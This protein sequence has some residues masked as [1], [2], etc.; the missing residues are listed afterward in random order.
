MH[1]VARHQR[2]RRQFDPLTVALDP[3]SE[4]QPLFEELERG[5]STALLE[6]A[7]GDVENQKDADHQS[8]DVF[9]SG[10]LQDDRSF[11][12]PRHRR[13]EMARESFDGMLALVGHRIRSGLRQTL[14]GLLAG[15]A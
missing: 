5:I 12:H 3:C 2:G 1:H 14:G 13:P 4:R 8:F 9:P 7:E 10:D 11:E 15:E 6:H